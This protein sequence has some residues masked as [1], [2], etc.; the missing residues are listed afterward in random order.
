[1]ILSRIIKPTIKCLFHNT[2]SCFSNKIDTNIGIAPVSRTK[3]ERNSNINIEVEFFG[4][5]IKVPTATAFLH[6]VDEI[7]QEKCYLFNTNSRD[8]YIIDCGSNIGL[9]ILYFKQEYPNA[10]IVGFEPDPKLFEMLEFNIKSSFGY[11]DVELNQGAVWVNDDELE[12]FI[13]GTLSGSLVVDFDKK[14]QLQKVQAFDIKR[15][16]GKKVDFLKLDIEG[17]ESNII[18]D[19]RSHL[20]NVNKLFFEFHDIKDKKQNLGHLLELLT[21]EGF[22]YYIKEASAILNHPFV[23][24]PSR[25]YLQ[26]LNIFCFREYE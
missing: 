17:A 15:Y 1:M 7:F 8:P 12:F 2:K 19:I 5:K 23:D 21:Q 20:K 24:K 6:S 16:L 3:L 10:R 11:K 22:K 18:L 13:D 14:N 26:Q 25:T 9:S 4:K